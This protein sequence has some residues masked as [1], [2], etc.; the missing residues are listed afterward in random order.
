ML[1]SHTVL[2]ASNPSTMGLPTKRREWLRAVFG[3]AW[4]T[5]LH[6]AKDEAAPG[7]ALLDFMQFIK[8]I[9]DKD[10]ETLQQARRY[11]VCK[12]RDLMLNTTPR[13][14]T[15]VVMVD[16]APLPVK[17]LVEH[18]ERYA[19]KDVLP[20]EGA[21]YLPVAWNERIPSP[22]IRFAGNY[23]LLQRELYPRLWND[24]ISCRYFTP[25]VGQ[26]LVL[27]GFPGRSLH[28]TDHQTGGTVWRPWEWD[29]KHDLPLTAEHEARDPD[30]YHRAYRV[31]HEPPSYAHQGGHI[32]VS[33]WEEA[34][35]SLAEVDYRMFWFDRFWPHD[36]LAF[37]C[38]DGD[39]F[40]VGGLFARERLI[41][42]PT[43][44][45]AGPGGTTTMTQRGNY[46][47]RNRHTVCLP[48]KGKKKRNATDDLNQPAFDWINLN[49]FY[50]DVCEYYKFREAEVQNPMATLVFL[51]ILSESD[52]VKK[53][54]YDMGEDTIIDPVFF[55][56]L[57]HFAY[58][59]QVTDLSGY[60]NLTAA[61]REI[62]LDEDM[63]R[64]FVRFCYVAKTTHQ[65]D[66]RTPRTP[67]MRQLSYADIKTRTKT[68]SKGQ[69]QAE[70]RKHMP[71]SEEIRLRCRQIEWNL[72]LWRNGPL[73]HEPD[74][75]EEWFGLPYYPYARDPATGKPKMVDA[76][77]P[78]QRCVDE[79]FAANLYR[80]KVLG[81]RVHGQAQRKEGSL[82]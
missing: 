67:K 75:F 48:Y 15:C 17:R 19:K 66:G 35:C 61:R 54:L 79:A 82:L 65:K 32:Q 62:I 39:V 76:V 44:E 38:N 42:P 5:T 52:Y 49:E 20:A 63:F 24:F 47:F 18:A 10:V 6:L 9:G 40:S 81:K 27:S 25:A 80:V 30:L 50:E 2:L 4:K 58:L 68:D 1:N 37:Y 69:P 26:T 45:I 60:S 8:V 57:P 51:L 28:V 31:F 78:R 71:E 3:R 41:S 36:H 34:R 12:V 23:K 53:F 55:D 21:P 11:F 46:H 72:S 13:I 74:P 77:S 7:V 59:V 29:E 64:L 16:L 33:E 56:N 22:W 70:R 14:H 43:L 73:G